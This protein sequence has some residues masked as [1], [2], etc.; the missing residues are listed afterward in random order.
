MLKD[1]EQLR[2]KEKLL[3]VAQL[4]AKCGVSQ[5]SIRHMVISKTI[6]HIKIDL[7]PYFS[8]SQIREWQR[9]LVIDRYIERRYKRRD[10]VRI[11]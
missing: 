7:I 6:P 2:L 4:A 9:E 10:N 1:E 3:S 8:M 11:L 5:T